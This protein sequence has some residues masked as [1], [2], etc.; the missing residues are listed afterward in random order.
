LGVF[1]SVLRTT[2]PWERFGRVILVHGVRVGADLVYPETIAAIAKTR[3]EQFTYIPVVSRESWPLA[4]AGRITSRL[5]SGELEDQVGTPI[6]PESSHV[7]LCGNS[8]MIRDARQILEGRG[9]I[10]HRSDVP[11]QYSAEHYH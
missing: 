4:L 10:R 6:S 1:L 2:D 9:L 5:A 11:G 8:A 7:M 3:G